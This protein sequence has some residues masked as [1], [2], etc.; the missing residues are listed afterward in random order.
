MNMLM[1]DLSTKEQQVLVADS[2]YGFM[3]KYNL[4]NLDIGYFN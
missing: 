2:I 3:T 1:I 4:L